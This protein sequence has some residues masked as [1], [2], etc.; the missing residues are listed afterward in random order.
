MRHAIPRS[1]S[2]P[3]EV[4]NQHQP[5]VRSRQQTGTADDR[6]VERCALRLGE[7]VD[8]VHIQDLLQPLI[9]RT[10]TRD[11]QMVRRDPQ[12][13]GSCQV[14]AST[15]GHAGVKYEGSIVSILFG[16]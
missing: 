1:E 7:R 3:C 4:P 14:L 10:S 12:S 8:G 6:G 15:H 13:R 11:R 16:L 9:E 5:E 2:M